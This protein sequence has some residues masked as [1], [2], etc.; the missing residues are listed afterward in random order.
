MQYNAKVI[1]LLR[2]VH[3][4]YDVVQRRMR[5]DIRRCTTSYDIVRTKVR[6]NRACLN[7]CVSRRTTSYDV[8]RSVNAADNFARVRLER[9]R[10]TSYGRTTS[11]V[12]V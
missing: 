8:A 10:R 12:V 7:F 1:E 9:P 4:A 5:R 3:T 2:G 11:Y 6:R